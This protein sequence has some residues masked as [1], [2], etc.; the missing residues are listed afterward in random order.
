MI[1]VTDTGTALS[2]WISPSALISASSR[3]SPAMN[4][5]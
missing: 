3:R 1:S 2:P 5:M 4:F